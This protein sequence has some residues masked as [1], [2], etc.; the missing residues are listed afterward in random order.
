LRTTLSRR[1]KLS[2]LCSPR[3]CAVLI[4]DNFEHPCAKESARR[5]HQLAVGFG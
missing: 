1:P 2:L 3:S 4:S 5:V